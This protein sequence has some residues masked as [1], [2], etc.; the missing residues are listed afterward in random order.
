MNNGKKN[1]LLKAEMKW[2]YENF[3]ENK[4]K[5]KNRKDG[6]EGNYLV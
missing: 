5:F 4:T 2:R 6:E 3:K 1:N